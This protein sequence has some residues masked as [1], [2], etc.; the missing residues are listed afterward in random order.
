MGGNKWERPRVFLFKDSLQDEEALTKQNREKQK[1][2]GSNGKSR[3]GE[4]L[5]DFYEECV[6]MSTALEQDLNKHNWF[7]A[8]SE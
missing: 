3:D 4:R 8:N 2:L 6:E 5:K 1:E 7:K